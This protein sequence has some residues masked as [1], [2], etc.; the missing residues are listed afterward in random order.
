[1]QIAENSSLGDTETQQAG[2][3]IHILEADLNR[4]S[5]A[6]LVRWT[7]DGADDSEAFF[8]FDQHHRIRDLVCIVGM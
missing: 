6:Y 4:K 5:F 1:M 2:F 7:I 8:Q 3:V